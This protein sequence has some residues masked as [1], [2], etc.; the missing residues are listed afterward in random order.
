METL[1]ELIGPDSN[2]GVALNPEHTNGL[3]N[4]IQSKVDSAIKEQ[5]DVSDDKSA[6][7]TFFAA[8]KQVNDDESQSRDEQVTAIQNLLDVSNLNHL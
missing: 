2:L 8:I 7:S 1:S 6:I 5:L 4:D 3:A